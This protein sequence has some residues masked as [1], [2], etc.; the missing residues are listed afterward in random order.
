[1]NYNYVQ[2]D[3]PLSPHNTFLNSPLVHNIQFILKLCVSKNLCLEKK[4]TKSTK[5]SC[6]CNNFNQTLCISIQY[7]MA[8]T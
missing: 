4:S 3:L 6:T 7:L 1:M 8:N 2:F 5:V